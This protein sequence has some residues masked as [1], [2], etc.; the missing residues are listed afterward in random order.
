MSND[1]DH[2]TADMQETAAARGLRVVIPE[3]NQLFL[4]IDDS[5]SFLVFVAN[6]GILGDLA[7]SQSIKPSPSGKAGRFHITVTLSRPVKDAFERIALQ[8]LLGSDR[9][10]ETLSW[11]AALAGMP[12]PTVFF[13]KP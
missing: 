11:R 12:N 4:D 7:E 9:K 3:P 5:E 2:Y 10:H 1:A 13:E 8:A 6:I